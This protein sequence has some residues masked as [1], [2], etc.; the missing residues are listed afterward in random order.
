VAAQRRRALNT[1]DGLLRRAFP[2][3][4]FAAPHVSPASTLHSL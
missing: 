4:I 2:Q 3:E 1:S